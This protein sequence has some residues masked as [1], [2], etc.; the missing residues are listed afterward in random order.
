MHSEIGLS[1]TA[2]GTNNG[3]GPGFPARCVRSV[4]IAEEI[5]IRGE[6]N[7]TEANAQMFSMASHK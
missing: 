6:A 7:Q 4:S 2:L 3:R 1:A 5:A